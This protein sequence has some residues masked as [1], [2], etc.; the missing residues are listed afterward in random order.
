MVNLLRRNVVRLSGVCK[1]GNARTIT[2]HKGQVTTRRFGQWGEPLSVTYPDGVRD[3]M[4]YQW[5]GAGLYTLT[6]LA[7]GRPAQVT[8][9]DAVG[10]E[11]RTGVQRFNGQWQYADKEYDNLGRLERAS[12][13]FRGSSPSYW[14]TY[15]YDYY[16][17]PLTRVESSGKITTWSY[18]G[19][20]V[21]ETVNGI[22][23]TRT[24]DSSGRVISVSDPGGTISY[25]LRPD[26]QPE[27]II[28]PGNIVTSFGYDTYGRQTSITDPSAGTQTYSETYVN[29]LLVRTVTDANDNT[30][31]TNYDKYGRVTNITRPEF[32]TS[33]VYNSDG[34]LGSETSVN[35]TVKQITYDAFARIQTA[36]ET[37]PDGKYLEKGFTYQNGNIAT[38]SYTS[39]GGLIA[40][41]HLIYENG[42]NTEMKLN[43]VTPVWKLTQENDLGQATRAL[44]GPLER[45]YTYTDYGIPTRRQ[46]GSLQDFSYNFDPM[47]GNLLSRTDNKRSITENFEYDNLNRLSIAGGDT[48]EY[49]PTGNITYMPDAGTMNYT[50]VDKPYAVTLLTPEGYAVPEREQQV[51]YTSFQRPGTITEDGISATFTYNSSGD[52]VKMNLTQ[53][54]PPILTRYYISGRYET[55]LQGGVERLYLGGDAYSAPAVYVK[56]VGVWR[57]YYVCR[58]YLGSITH[59]A[60]A[61]G[62]LKQE[63]SYTAWGRLRNPS[64]QAA[65]SPGSE[66]SI[67]LGRGYTGHEQLVWFGLINMNARLYDPALGRFLSPDPFVQAPEYSQNFNRYSYAL[68]NPLIYTDQDGEFFIGTIFTFIVDLFNTIEGVKFLPTKEMRQ[69]AWRRFDPSA[70]WSKTNKAWK[71]DIGGFKTDPNRNDLGRGLQLISRWTWEV[72]QTMV[73]KLF[74]HTRNIFGGV[75]NVEYYGGATLVNRNNEKKDRGGLTLGPYINS[76]RLVANPYEDELFR[77]EYGHTLQSRLVGLFYLTKVGIPSLIG[78]FLDYKLGIN[79]HDREWYETQA[80]SMA[81]RYFRNHEPDALK[82]L[83]WNFD[84]YPTEYNP[85][86]YWIFAHPPGLFSWWLLF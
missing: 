60:N 15:T 38:V 46:A 61:D 7:T 81:E 75:D 52:R 10:R 23:S 80:N 74:S 56:E 21:T 40:T 57:L 25:S 82:E 9:Y 42:H 59:I 31:I 55:D 30:V 1:Y 11:V 68:N 2:N 29:N 13:P 54:V 6:S 65:Y 47:K 26:G 79:D 76:N 70:P 78:A 3:S 67:F 32:N 14:T 41:E 5:G 36:R 84:T 45:I 49:S 72:P 83:P 43:G 20:S 53:G 16:D 18:S 69:E 39:Q 73:G 62:T 44:T 12:L 51:S 77:H 50:R 48:I 19:N 86:W 24:F 37:V 4:T 27:S 8:H 34:L 33:Y 63:L 35:G 58:D 71:I 17:R 28:A 64:T 85:S 66:P 22:A